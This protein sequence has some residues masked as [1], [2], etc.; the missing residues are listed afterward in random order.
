MLVKKIVL[1]LFL[2]L[3]GVVTKAETSAAQQAPAAPVDPWGISSVTVAGGPI[4]THH[5]QSGTDDF[6]DHHTLGIV[7]ANTNGYGNWALYFLGPNSVNKNSYG[8]GYVTDPY[9]IPMGPTQLELSGA[10]GLVTGY[11]NYPV[12]LLG[13]QAQLVVYKNGPW[14]AGLEMAAM[15]YIAEDQTTGKNKVG[16]VGTTPF[17]S[18]RYKFQ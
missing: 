11:Q 10:L 17:L 6:V 5:F 13:A 12:P 15:P 4:L 8:A 14:N 7:Q 16:I 1:T 3:L 2:C 9:V 18:I